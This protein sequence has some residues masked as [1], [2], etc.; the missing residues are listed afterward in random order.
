MRQMAPI[1]I[2]EWDTSTGKENYMP[3]FDKTDPSLPDTNWVYMRADVIG[4]LG[5][6][7]G[8]TV[9][10]L[11]RGSVRWE[12]HSIGRHVFHQFGGRDYG[13][14][15]SAK[16]GISKALHVINSRERTKRPYT[17]KACWLVEIREAQLTETSTRPKVMKRR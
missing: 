9:I 6:L 10:R 17:K 14:I 1:T 4:V 16:R 7:R 8:H 15:E 12:I 13:D 3:F 2:G 11:D 5:E